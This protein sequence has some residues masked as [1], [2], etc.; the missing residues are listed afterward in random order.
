M[1]EGNFYW[2]GRK[3]NTVALKYHIAVKLQSL[4]SITVLKS[5]VQTIFSASPDTKLFQKDKRKHTE[6]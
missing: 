4:N 5:L 1:G 3:K 6:W 2:S